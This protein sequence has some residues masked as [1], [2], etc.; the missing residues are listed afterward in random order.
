MVR[1]I[2]NL[3]KYS[4]VLNAINLLLLVQFAYP[5]IYRMMMELLVSALQDKDPIVKVVV[6]NVLYRIV[7]FVHRLVMRFVKF[8]TPL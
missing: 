5:H 2:V 8:V 3:V 6:Q 7:L 1:D 4:I